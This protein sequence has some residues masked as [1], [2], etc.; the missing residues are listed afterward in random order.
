MPLDPEQQQAVDA[1]VDANLLVEAGPGRGKTHVLSQRIARL[2]G[3]QECEAGEI[4]VL[5]FSR[6]ARDELS[7][8]LKDMTD[9][10]DVGAVNLRTIDSLASQVI[11][12]ALGEVDGT[13]DERIVEAMGIVKDDP[14][15]AGLAAYRHVLVD[16]AQDVVGIRASFLT[17]LWENMPQAGFTIFADKAQAIYDFCL[18]SKEG[19]PPVTDTTQ[20]IEM[21]NCFLTR[22]VPNPVQEVRLLRYYRSSDSNQQEL[23]TSVWTKLADAQH[24]DAKAA[25]DELLG[26]FMPKGPLDDIAWAPGRGKTR[27]VLC[28]QNGQALYAATQAHKQGKRVRLQRSDR[29][30][31]TPAWVG[32]LLLGRP[33]GFDVSLAFLSTVD[34]NVLPPGSDCRGH[35]S[36]AQVHMSMW[37]VRP[38]GSPSG[39]RC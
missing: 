37:R 32:R 36:I 27:A 18:V 11:M 30:G 23:C 20:S 29:L 5:S 33:P 25:I 35:P 31:E 38:Q 6:A 34:S 7:R 21:L 15:T 2:I 24:T 14:E 28:P 17:A 10:P 13:F 26:R 12:T 4:L 8:R 1:P 19:E 3:D 39:G 9:H 22:E 16:E